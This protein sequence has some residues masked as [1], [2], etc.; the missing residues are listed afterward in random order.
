[1]VCTLGM[2]SNIVIVADVPES[3]AI[4]KISFGITFELPIAT[5]IMSLAFILLNVIARN[6]YYLAKNIC[7]VLGSLFI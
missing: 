4:M 6:Y 5:E 2:Q 3:S 7:I 1:M